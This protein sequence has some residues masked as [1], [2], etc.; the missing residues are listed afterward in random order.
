[1][2]VG[3]QLSTWVLHVP[4]HLPCALLRQAPPKRAGPLIL[5]LPASLPSPSPCPAACSGVVL[6]HQEPP[7]ARKPTAR[8]RLYVF[9]GGKA[10]EEP[11]YIHRCGNGRAG[12]SV[13]AW[14]RGQV[15][16]CVQGGQ[17]A[18]RAAVHTQV[19]RWG[20]RFVGEWTGRWVGWC[21]Y[22]F[23]GGKALEEPLYIHRW[24]D[25]WL[26]RCVGRK[27]HVLK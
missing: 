15:P 22:V 5:T 19:G 7:E 8:W 25:G 6:L 9:K 20:G 14:V 21:L 26:G 4:T 1:M 18:G 12:L 23:K 3:V 27:V 17:G 11:L 16:V 10:L 13:G 2:H 24:G